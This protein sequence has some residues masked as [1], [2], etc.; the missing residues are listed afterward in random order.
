MNLR[1]PKLKD[2]ARGQPCMNCGAQDDTTVWAHSN[3]QEDGKGM[4]I[5]AHD[6]IGAW[7]C[8]KCHLWL[9]QGIGWD[10]THKYFCRASEKAEMFD[11]AFRKT[12]IELWEQGL[13]R[14]S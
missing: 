14:M 9:D 7:L 8:H 11:R 2:S 1:I 5:K 12:L 4:G 6:C 10:P 3:R 13:V